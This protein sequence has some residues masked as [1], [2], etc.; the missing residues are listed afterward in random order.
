MSFK[1]GDAVRILDK[2]IPNIAIYLGSFSGEDNGTITFNGFPFEV[3]ESRLE[4]LNI[5]D[6]NELIQ[7]EGI[8]TGVSCKETGKNYL[9][10]KSKE[11]LE[12]VLSKDGEDTFVT[13]EEL[14]DRYELSVSVPTSMI[15]KEK[16]NNPKI[17]RGLKKPKVSCVP[18]S[19]FIHLGQAMSDGEKKYGLM[20]WRD[21]EVIA[22]IYYDAAFRHL[23][24]WWDGEEEAED[25]GAKHLAHVMACCAI[26]LDAHEN[27]NLIDDR[28][29][30]GT[31][32]K[33]I[34][35]L[36]KNEI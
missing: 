35:R 2:D 13:E 26:L 1:S 9:I 36:T 33:L 3:P 18:P 12:F 20:N 10:N 30:K 22:S 6:I 29:S 32:N 19:A 14:F 4:K 24:A 15:N 8:T 21:S 34:E 16:V 7:V 11:T 25:S 31:V 23:M 17:T 28:P 5:S 27:G